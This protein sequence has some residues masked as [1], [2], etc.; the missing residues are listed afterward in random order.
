MWLLREFTFWK[1]LSFSIKMGS[2]GTDKESSNLMLLFDQ[3]QF[4]RIYAFTRDW[5]LVKFWLEIS[6]ISFSKETNKMSVAFLTI[7]PSSKCPPKTLHPSSAKLR[8]RWTSP[9]LKCP[10]RDTISKLPSN[11]LISWL[12]GHWI[13]AFLRLPTTPET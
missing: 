11:I 3:G 7:E 9:L 6:I 4:L 1:S 5:F 8:W 10:L 13:L 12:P 2:Y